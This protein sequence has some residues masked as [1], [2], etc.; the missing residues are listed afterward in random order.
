M[1]EAR[2]DRAVRRT[3]RGLA[4]GAAV[5]VLVLVAAS[6]GRGQDGSIRGRVQS[7]GTGVAVAGAQV[8][9]V[10]LD[11]RVR[12]DADGG[13]RLGGLPAGRYTLEVR[14]PFH[15]P[16]RLE[17]IEVAD[18][19]EV[20]RDV[21][22]R[23]DPFRLPQIEVVADPLSALRRLPGSASVLSAETLAA[24]QPVSAVEAL[25]RVPGVVVREDSGPFGLRPNIGIRGLN[26]DRSRKILVLEDGI[27]V[28]LA[29]YGEPEMYYSPP[30]ERMERIEVVKGSGS[31]RFGPQTIGGVVN[32]RTPDPP[33]EPSGSVELWGGDRGYLK[34]QGW[35]G[36]TIGRVGGQASALHKLGE[37]ARG[38]FFD[39][40]D[41]TGKVT[42]ELSSRSRVGL[43]LNAY[44][45]SSA[46]TYLGLT[47]PMWEA[48]P[49]Q[50][51]VPED[52]LDVRRL[53]GSATHRWSPGSQLTIQTTVYGHHVSRNWRRQDFDREDRGREYVAIVGDTSIPGGALFLRGTNGHR[54][55]SFDVMG[56]ETRAAWPAGILGLASEVELGVRLHHERAL[57]Q[58][59]NGSSPAAATGELVQDETRTGRAL[60]AFVQQRVELSP[61]L[62]VTGGLRLERFTFD[63]HVHRDL[64]DGEPV[65]LDTRAEDRVSDWVP[66]I[67]LTYTPSDA[68]TLFAGVHRG[69]APPRIKDA[70]S[71]AGQSVYLEAERSWNTELGVRS[72]PVDWLGAE[73]TLFRMD[74]S[75]QV[76]PASE[77]VGGSGTGLV[78]AGATLHQGAEVLGYLEVGELL[79]WDSSLRVDGNYTWVRAEFAAGIY[80]GN[81][82]PY[83]PEHVFSLGI[84]LARPDGLSAYLSGIAMAS[85]FSD[86]EE[87]EAASADGLIGRIPSFRVWDVTVSRPLAGG[88][89]RALITVKNLFDARYIASRAPLGIQPGHPRQANIGFRYH[90]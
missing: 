38:I 71:A 33:L 41:V 10:E 83:A 9:V 44:D 7:A 12:A 23:P 86:N 14:A 21:A 31:I 2:W 22:L 36:G 43:K 78:N 73:L 87:T 34:A 63:R 79:G 75:N 25:R 89:L 54:N 56:V 64:A 88:P 60:A 3:R 20:E 19:A 13:Y 68:L 85:Q 77:S 49:W 51:P 15:L 58:R 24:V 57:E 61:A 50:N 29:A 1:G 90:L 26:P 66:G 27:P 35:Y 72:R 62:H 55:R 47:Q 52:R 80:D 81:R 11:R 67:G 8:G 42:T 70:I 76:I 18:E 39:V 37:G 48:N 59:V 6:A 53:A 16:A 32:Y 69:F 28:A 65:D 17:G 5:A 45:E 46:S 40:T 4:A 74:F 84:A 82:L 30:I